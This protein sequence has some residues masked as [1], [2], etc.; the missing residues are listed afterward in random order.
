[1]STIYTW[2]KPF[3]SKYTYIFHNDALAGQLKTLN[4]TLTT[5]ATLNGNKY[6]FESE[7][8][9]RPSS[10]IINSKTKKIVGEIQYS[11]FQ[12]KATI[13]IGHHYF[14]W[15]K[16]SAFSR[17]WLLLDSNG[18]CILENFKR[19]TVRVT[20]H[21]DSELLLLCALKSFENFN[22]MG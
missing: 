15:K 3:L 18:V 6:L 4:I 9:I 16:F 7:G 12:K 19:K 21:P 5:L 13:Q 2:K 17:R 14:Y 1:M 8:I 20:D 10:L 22:R 11:G